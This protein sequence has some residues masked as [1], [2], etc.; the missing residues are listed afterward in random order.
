MTQ[1]TRFA[2]LYNVVPSEALPGIW[3]D[4]LRDVKPEL[5]KAV[6]LRLEGEFVPT[7]ACP[8]PV[9]AHI[10]QLLAKVNEGEKNVEA[11]L[12]WR[13]ALDW[14][15][16][17][18]HPDFVSSD[19]P[20]LPAKARQAL[21]AA[22]GAAYLYSASEEETQW[23]KKRFIEFYESLGQLQDNALLLKGGQAKTILR[24]LMPADI[25]DRL[26]EAKTL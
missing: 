12:A 18:W 6:L 25:S 26:L 8:F 15:R 23:A 2:A 5:L 4:A 11:E 16:N 24:S 17:H 14:S 3:L 10:R 19:L 22:G 7:H 20:D 13:Q 9:P 21:G 1:D